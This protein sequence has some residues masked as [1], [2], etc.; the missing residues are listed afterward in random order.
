MVVRQITPHRKLHANFILPG[1]SA[2]LGSKTEVNKSLEQYY[3]Y[4]VELARIQVGHSSMLAEEFPEEIND[5]AQS[6]LIAFWQRL[7]SEKGQINSPKAYISHIVHSRGVDMIRQ[8]QRKPIFPLPVDQDGELYQGRV[9]LIPSDGMQDPAL[10]FERK[11]F[12]TEVIDD[13]L[14]LPPHQRYAMICTLKDELGDSLL[15][16]EAFSKRGIDIGT[17]NWPQDTVE[18][19]KLRSSLSVARKK[20]RFSKK[21]YCHA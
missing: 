10:E 5:L 21:K 1:P 7:N 13:V 9:I 8:R 19:Q 11:E 12:I 15:L 3:Q 17:I 16:V 14:K 6:T 2:S 4:I 18:L 20:L